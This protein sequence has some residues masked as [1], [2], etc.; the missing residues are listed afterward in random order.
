MERK[1]NLELDTSGDI[2]MGDL[3]GENA[4]KEASRVVVSP[5]FTKSTKIENHGVI[6]KDLK[7]K[8][9]LS[10]D[11]KEHAQIRKKQKLEEEARSKGWE[12]T[13]ST[14]SQSGEN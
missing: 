13:A 1:E 3:T 5:F 14:Q 8:L 2:T 11:P 7:R 9:N 6:A 4:G 10:Y 12:E